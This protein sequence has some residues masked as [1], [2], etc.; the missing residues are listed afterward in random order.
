[1]SGETR[2]AVRLTPRA[3]ADAIEGWAKDEAGRP[4]LK[5]RVRAQPVDGK[6]NAALEALVAEALGLPKSAV[7]VSAGGASRLKHLTVRGLD[8]AEAV[9]LLGGD[10]G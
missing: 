8:E 1:L 9:R 5:A 4:Y 6:A 2:I 7:T 3:K 10:R